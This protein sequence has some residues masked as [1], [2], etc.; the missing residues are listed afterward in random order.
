MYLI[1]IFLAF[2]IYIKSLK[3]FKFIFGNYK[4]ALDLF[5][6]IIFQKINIFALKRCVFNR[7][8]DISI[9]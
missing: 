9:N 7:V 6:N 1:F 2:L 5:S 8:K 4:I 3:D